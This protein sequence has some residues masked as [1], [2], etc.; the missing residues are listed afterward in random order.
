MPGLQCHEHNYIRKLICCAPGVLIGFGPSHGMCLHGLKEL[1]APVPSHKEHWF[2]QFLLQLPLWWA[3]LYKTWC[4]AFWACVHVAFAHH[5]P[6]WCNY[7]ASS[8]CFIEKTG[9]NLP[10]GGCWNIWLAVGV[11]SESRSVDIAMFWLFRTALACL[12]Q[13]SG[14]PMDR[15]MQFLEL[16]LPSII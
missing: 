3:A 13:F 5:A 7:R 8:F 6:V 10:F 14:V 2:K 15:I 11:D 16:C 4:P 9:R 1:A 12:H